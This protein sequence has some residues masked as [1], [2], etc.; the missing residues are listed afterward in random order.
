[1]AAHAPVQH[2]WEMLRLRWQTCSSARH[3]A[4]ALRQAVQPAMVLAP[5]GHARA[6]ATASHRTMRFDWR[7]KDLLQNRV[8]CCAALVRLWPGEQGPCK[9]AAPL[10]GGLQAASLSPAAAPNYQ[11]QFVSSLWQQL[12]ACCRTQTIS[13]IFHDACLAFF[14]RKLNCTRCFIINNSALFLFL[15]STPLPMPKPPL[16]SPQFLAHTT[17]SSSSTCFAAATQWDCTHCRMEQNS[18]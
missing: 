9:F 5:P 17:T 15:P 14:P 12:G 18:G 7:P 10:I 3:P 11:P 8:E 4:S 13:T 1:M 2:P 16:P 6:A